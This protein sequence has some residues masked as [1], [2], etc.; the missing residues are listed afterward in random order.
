[1]RSARWKRAGRKTSPRSMAGWAAVSDGLASQAV[2][3]H[4]CH[5]QPATSGRSP[6]AHPPPAQGPQSRGRAAVHRRSGCNRR[7]RATQARAHQLSRRSS[8]SRTAEPLEV[9]TGDV[10]AGLP[11]VAVLALP[12]A[13]GVTVVVSGTA[14][15]LWCAK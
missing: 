5:D 1:V 9:T 12:G 10:R 6:F 14:G 3:S 4:R 2:T 8:P 7:Q 15:W 13:P 11:P